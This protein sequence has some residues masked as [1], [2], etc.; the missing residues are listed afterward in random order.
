MDNVVIQEITAKDCSEVSRVV[1]ASFAWAGKQEGFSSAEIDSYVQKR[2][3]ES[4]IR[5]QSKDY[6]F[7]VTIM[8]DQICG[9]VAIEKNEIT[10][11]YV[12]PAVHR[13]N[14]GRILFELAE[15]VVTTYP[16][17]QFGYTC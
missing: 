15:R 11:I 1:C 17:V 9:T 6:R 14:I 3:S 8:D 4:A 7:W 10:K 16:W 13:H 12:D 2:G 5:N